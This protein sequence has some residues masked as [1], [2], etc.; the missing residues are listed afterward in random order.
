MANGTVSLDER[1]M[2][3]VIRDEDGVTYCIRDIPCN[4]CEAQGRREYCPEI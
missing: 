1:N 3:T 2:G 4:K